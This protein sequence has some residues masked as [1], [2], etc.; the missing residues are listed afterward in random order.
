MTECKGCECTARAVHKLESS[1]NYLLL[2]GKQVNKIT[3]ENKK[4]I[5]ELRR[6]ERDALRKRFNVPTTDLKNASSKRSK[7]NVQS[8]SSR[9]QNKSTPMTF[10]TEAC[11]PS[12]PTE[13]TTTSCDTTRKSRGSSTVRIDSSSAVSTQKDQTGHIQ[14]VRN[15]KQ[16]I[17]ASIDDTFIR[18]SYTIERDGS[19]LTLPAMVKVK[20]LPDGW[21]DVTYVMLSEHNHVLMRLTCDL[22]GTQTRNVVIN[23]VLVKN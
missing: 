10:V 2:E 22:Y 1:I 3:S 19:H 11:P 8:E 9:K 12:L 20:Q 17:N 13:F 16:S 14:L 5:E 7:S 15:V 23:D 21:L 6:A 4:K 18:H